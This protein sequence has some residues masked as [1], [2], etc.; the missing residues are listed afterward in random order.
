MVDDAVAEGGLGQEGQDTDPGNL[1]RVEVFRRV[2]GH[3]LRRQLHPVLLPEDTEEVEGDGRGDPADAVEEVGE[4]GGHEVGHLV[5]GHDT[6][7]L[8]HDEEGLEDQ[9]AGREKHGQQRGEAARP[10]VDITFHNSNATP[11]HKRNGLLGHGLIPRLSQQGG[12]VLHSESR[13]DKGGVAVHLGPGESRTGVLEGAEVFALEKQGQAGHSQ[14][15]MDGFDGVIDTHLEK[16]IKKCSTINGT[17]N[18]G[19]TTR[20]TLGGV[21]PKLRPAPMITIGQGRRNGGTDL[22]G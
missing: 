13:L 5:R 16:Q 17:K 7:R 12:V 9:K 8:E 1:L 14:Q 4:D 19:Q 10:A 2:E 21:F 20:I 11:Q 15:E 6:G 18:F 22:M 3:E